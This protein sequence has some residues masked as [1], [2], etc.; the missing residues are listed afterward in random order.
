MSEDVHDES[1]S[2]ACAIVARLPVRSGACNDATQ[3]ACER[4]R[5]WC[6]VRDVVRS[7]RCL[8]AILVV[9]LAYAG[10]ARA[11]DDSTRCEGFGLDDA[12]VTARLHDVRARIARNEP[13]VRHWLA[14]FSVLHA[15]LLGGEMVL[16]FTASSDGGRVDA[17]IGAI[18]SGLGLATLL[19]SFPPIVGAGGTLDDMPEDTP[20]Q[21]LAKLVRA[22]RLLHDSADATSFV[23]GPVASLLSAGY[24]AVAASIQIVGFGREVGGY[25]LMAGGIV[26]GQG[27]LLLHPDGTL[28]DW[29]RYRFLHPDAGCEPSV[30]ASGAAPV[31]WRLLPTAM[32]GGAGLGLTLTF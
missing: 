4:S 9:S 15:A 20:E 6:S 25:V 5:F 11:Q 28:H 18:S 13:D 26:L 17:V 12:E 24:V 22:E 31:A 14:A 21:R 8:A 2:R 10:P 30:R 23:R 1:P 3:H 16:G 27:R 32:P 7:E 19:I 29:R